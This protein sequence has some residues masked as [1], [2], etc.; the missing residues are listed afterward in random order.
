MIKD[1]NGKNQKK[2]A[3]IAGFK[4][5]DLEERIRIE[6]HYHG[7]KSFREIS[8]LLGG[9]SISTISDEIDGKLRKGHG[10]YSTYI[11]HESALVKRGERGRRP[12]LKS[13]FIIDY[14]VEKLKLGWSPEQI[15]LRLPIDHKKQTIS[16]EAIYEY[17]YAQIGVSG[18]VKKDSLDLRIYLP[19]RHKRR[20]KKGLRKGHKFPH[21]GTLP[22]I[23]TRPK[24][25]D[26]RKE[27][28]NWEDDSIVS[29]KSLD[30]LKSINE[31]ACGILLLSKV[32]N[33]TSEESTSAVCNRLKHIPSSYLRTLTRDNGTEN[34]GWREIEKHLNL[35]VYF[36]HPYSSW[37]RGSNENLNGL[38][39]RFFT[40]KTDFSK[41]TEE[42]VKKVEYL[43]N[44]R[45]RKRFKGLTPY[46]V[47]FKKTG[48]RL[49]C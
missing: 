34:M 25:V 29:R 26:T 33:G 7:G 40:K 39:R 27:V 13:Q 47:F 35:K 49:E 46:E 24:S 15:S 37:E 30:R 44:S 12:R 38:V 19:R 6:L 8:K 22:R 36:A 32:K 17:I 41:V 45:P 5:L 18:K 2:K 11:A 42:E 1:R 16:H 10:K 23:D 3:K 48:V 28:G 43:I 21:S 4:Q 20:V 9:R 14:V 31:R